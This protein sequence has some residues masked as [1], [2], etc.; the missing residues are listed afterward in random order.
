MI[1][2]HECVEM[3]SGMKSSTVRKLFRHGDIG[4]ADFLCHDLE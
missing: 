1:Y 2:V 4:F 3:A